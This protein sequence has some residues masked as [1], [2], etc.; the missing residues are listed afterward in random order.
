M[1]IGGNPRRKQFWKKMLDK[2]RKKKNCSFGEGGHCLWPI[3]CALSNL[4]FH[5]SRY[6]FL[7]IFRVPKSICKEIIKLQR[8]FLWEWGSVER[9][10]AWI[11]GESYVSL[12]RKEG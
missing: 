5:L 10:I 11:D 8:D 2:V 7:S 9:K 3:E 12:R 6:I 4:Y 1:P